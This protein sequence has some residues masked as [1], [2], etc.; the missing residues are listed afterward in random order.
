MP[1][2]SE[3]CLDA[4]TGLSLGA[5][6]AQE[7]AVLCDVPQGGASGIVVLADGL[8]GHVAGA[9]ASRIAV[10]TALDELA[11]RRNAQGRLETDIPGL[12]VNAAQAANRAI[13]AHACSNPETHGMGATLLLV[14][15][16]G[17]RLFWLSVGDS[18][19]FL[20]RDGQIRQL[21]EVHS[22]A[23]Q[24]DLLARAGEMDPEIAASHPDR[25]CLTS[26]LGFDPLRRV[27]CPQTGF[28]LAP[29][30]LLVA[31]SDGILTLSPEMMVTTLSRPDNGF[32][33]DLVDRL[34]RKV[35]ASGAREQDNLSVSV[36]RLFPD[37]ERAVQPRHGWARRLFQRFRQLSPEPSPLGVS[38]RQ[39]LPAPTS[40][41]GSG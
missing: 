3:L 41:E 28:E 5:R 15:V 9:L 37:T 17:G 19:L 22:L 16:D 1:P 29:G 27:D 14:I 8:G 12:L 6:E 18:P 33:T 11:A 32:A 23:P 39:D 2:T 30:D 35:A 34:L 26:A 36:L 4:A 24:F 21:N 31:A 38:L 13:L 10:T 7:D 20:L 25:S 40:V